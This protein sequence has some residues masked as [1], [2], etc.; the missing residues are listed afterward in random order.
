MRY[1]SLVIWVNNILLG[2]TNYYN[3]K[4]INSLDH[5]Q[6]LQNS[7]IELLQLDQLQSLISFRQWLRI[8]K[9][10]QIKLRFI[11]S[12][13]FSFTEP[14]DQDLFHGFTALSWWA[15]VF[16]LVCLPSQSLLG[17][18]LSGFAASSVVS[19]IDLSG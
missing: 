6:N 11:G 5:F 3:I 1:L 4:F 8:N 18:T 19:A 13:L 2:L 15:L 7:Y 14:L 9:D 17:K 10:E 16:T 12:F